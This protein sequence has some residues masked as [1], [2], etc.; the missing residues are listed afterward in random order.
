M[1]L[2]WL[3]AHPDIHTP[4]TTMTGWVYGMPSAI[5]LGQGEKM[6]TSLSKS[7]VDPK[8][9]CIFGAQFIDPQEI[10]NIKSLV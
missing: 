2:H 8:N 7:Y 3:D 9:L 6:L 4:Q 1:S 10:E 5:V